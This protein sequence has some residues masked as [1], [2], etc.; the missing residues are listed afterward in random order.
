M[1][2]RDLPTLSI[3]SRRRRIIQSCRSEAMYNFVGNRIASYNV[4][5]RVIPHIY[6]GRKKYYKNKVTGKGIPRDAEWDRVSRP[7][8]L[9]P[10]FPS[11][12]FNPTSPFIETDGQDVVY[13]FYFRDLRPVKGLSSCT[14]RSTTRIAATIP[15]RATDISVTNS[16]METLVSDTSPTGS[17]FNTNR[18]TSYCHISFRI[19]QRPGKMWRLSIPPF[20]A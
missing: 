19:P 15:I 11:S 3:T 13:I 9:F 17:P 10:F 18:K 7:V 20:P 5:V 2:A 1:S 12:S 14:S 16:A 4:T 6:I 8:G